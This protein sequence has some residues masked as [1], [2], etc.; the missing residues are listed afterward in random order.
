MDLMAPFLEF[1]H[2]TRPAPDSRPMDTTSRP[3]FAP[4]FI[5]DWMGGSLSLARGR[6]RLRFGVNGGAGAHS[7]RAFFDPF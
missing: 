5:W 2:L 3:N 4:F 1:I 6:Q 7:R